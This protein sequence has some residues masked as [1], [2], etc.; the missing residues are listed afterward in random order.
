[1]ASERIVVDQMGYEVGVP[2]IPRRIVSLVPSQTELIY[3]LG[4]DDSLVGITKFCIHPNHLLKE[5]AIIGGTKDFRFDVIDKLQP[6]LIIGNKE[7][8]YEEGIDILKKKYPVW[9]SDIYT[10]NDA[11]EMIRSI[12]SILNTQEQSQYLITS[13]KNS[14]SKIHPKNRI[15]ALYFI[16]NSPKM[17]VGSNT[18]I[19]EML[20]LAGFD[21]VLQ[22][23]RYP[24]LT[25]D[26]IKEFNPDVILLSSEPFPFKEKHIEQF[27][28]LVPNAIIKI[29]DGELFSWYG[30]RLNLA[31]DYINQLLEEISQQVHNPSSN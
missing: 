3:D 28:D 25:D 11:F 8:N 31:P 24:E 7:E 5:K 2:H 26:Q 9:M 17:A 12:G 19:N 15:K 20:H 4:C 10:L 13:I 18:F 23:S 21:N 16:W 29:V 22:D 6:D 14:F 1:M 27:R 30:S